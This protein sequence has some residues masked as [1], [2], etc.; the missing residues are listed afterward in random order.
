VAPPLPENPVSRPGDLWLLPAA[1]GKRDK[2][3][4][5]ALCGD[6][7]GI[8]DTSTFHDDAS[9]LVLTVDYAAERCH[10]PS[11]VA[12]RSWVTAHAEV[13]PLSGQW[14][15]QAMRNILRIA[16]LNGN[17]RPRGAVAGPPASGARSASRA[18]RLRAAP[19]PGPRRSRGATSSGGMVQEPPTC[20]NPVPPSHYCAL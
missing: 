19:L 14:R 11:S 3:T 1:V 12:A 6:A 16:L 2:G 15:A 20:P 4:H 18:P 8:E 5:R 9:I 7:T 10:I 17:C 13:I